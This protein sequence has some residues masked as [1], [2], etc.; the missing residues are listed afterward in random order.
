MEDGQLRIYQFGPTAAAI[1]VFLVI[2]S[3]L[4]IVIPGGAAPKAGEPIDEA[5]F[6]F[7]A[8]RLPASP[9]ETVDQE[10][11]RQLLA[12]FDADAKHVADRFEVISYTFNGGHFQLEVRHEDGSVYRVSLGGVRHG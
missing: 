7:F 3:F 10:G 1:A 4:L 6:I 9:P 8:M 11:L 5:W 12:D 2:S